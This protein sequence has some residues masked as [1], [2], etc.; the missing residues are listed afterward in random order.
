MGNWVPVRGS[1]VS[2]GSSARVKPKRG[3]SGGLQL[4]G[5]V[6][7]VAT[8]GVPTGTDLCSYRQ[9]GGLSDRADD[10]S[11]ANGIAQQGGAGAALGHFLHRTTHVD[12][13]DLCPPLL[14]DQ[15]CLSHHLRL[16][17]EN[18]ERVGML[19]P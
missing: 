10:L 17:A 15:R 9:T 11:S 16:A 5:D 8:G 13:D 4:S 7:V 1:F 2:L 3:A 12:V 14:A 6:Q 18:L 19:D